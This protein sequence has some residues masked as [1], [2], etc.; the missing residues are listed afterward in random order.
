MGNEHQEDMNQI[1]RV[2]HDCLIYRYQILIVIN[3]HFEVHFSSELIQQ[4][5][6]LQLFIALQSLLFVHL[7]WP[8]LRTACIWHASSILNNLIPLL[9]PRTRLGLL[10]YVSLGCSLFV[11]F[12]LLKVL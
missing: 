1:Q 4:P 11:M 2:L 10:V 6:Y 8:S 5:I 9:G 7:V 3:Q 12:S